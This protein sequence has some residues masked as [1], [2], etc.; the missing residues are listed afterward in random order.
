MSSNGACAAAGCTRQSEYRIGPGDVL[1]ISVWKDN[2]LGQ[3]VTVR[4]D[5]MVTLPLINDIQA[6]GLTPMQLR[7][8]ISAKLKQY[9][10]DPNVAV[11]VQA[12]HSFV[13][14]VLG[15]VN[16]PGRY[17]LDGPATVL[18]V[19]ARA[20]GLTD[21]ASPSKIVIFRR[22]ES[23][24]KRIAFDYDRVLSARDTQTNFL[25]QQYDIVMVP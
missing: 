7:D 9:L 13:V 24:V 10:T 25:V 8:D 18:D 20:G 14:S 22:Y 19:L 3:T 11:V 4:P 1:H 6:S 15:Q 16:K 17:E 21:F 23:G 12:V 2:E 5:G